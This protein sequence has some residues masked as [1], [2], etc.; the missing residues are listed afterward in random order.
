MEKG[1][2]KLHD[3]VA[4]LSPSGRVVVYNADQ[5]EIFNGF[6]ANFVHSEI[7]KT[8]ADEEV[9]HFQV[10]LRKFK[11]GSEPPEVIDVTEGNAGLYKFADITMRIYNCIYLF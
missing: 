7:M 2:I 11:R 9:K 8:A 6:R 1:N 4:I 3:L 5:E 10:E